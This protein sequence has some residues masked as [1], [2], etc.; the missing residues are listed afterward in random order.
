M[1]CCVHVGQ[2]NQGDIFAT[3]QVRVCLAVQVCGM[4]SSSPLLSSPLSS[5]LSF[6]SHIS[7]HLSSLFSQKF[8]WWL[9]ICIVGRSDHIALR[10]S[11]TMAT[12]MFFVLFCLVCYPFS[13]CNNPAR[14]YTQVSFVK[15]AEEKNED[16]RV[17]KQVKNTPF[18][19]NTS[20]KVS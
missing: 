4:E 10:M 8:Q 15:H 5:P 12:T 13:E 17:L 11:C 9:L 7:S 3:R 16:R 14:A 6:S 20:R 19:L 18:N 2:R 1:L